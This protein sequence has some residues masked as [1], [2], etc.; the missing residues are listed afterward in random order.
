VLTKL[1]IYEYDT[2]VIGGNIAALLYSYNNNIP[3]IINNLNPPHRFEQ[4]GTHS[5]LELWK[6]LY[7]LLSLSG[8]NL[9]GDKA[10]YIRIK[11]ENIFSVATSNSCSIKVSFD[12]LIVFDDEN[13]SGLPVSIEE[14][15]Q[16]SNKFLVLDWMVAKPCMEHDFEHFHTDDEFV[17]DIYFYP[18]ERMTGIHPRKKDVVAISYLTAEQL[19]EFEYSDTYARFKT[20]KIMKS[21]G[22]T[23]RKNG[24]ANGKQ[25]HYTLKLEVDRRE[26]KKIKMNLYN[27][28]KNIE[29]KYSPPGDFLNERILIKSYQ[30][31]LNGFFKVI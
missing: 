3:I 4:I 11:D 18:T 24:Y 19:Q 27:N 29:F 25:I 5:K 6:K 23:G 15:S 28:T 26:V 10:Q 7:F 1:P 12:K 21:H 9:V 30:S 16:T 8:L 13:V 20:T 22:I 17:R 31:K 14:L 2:I